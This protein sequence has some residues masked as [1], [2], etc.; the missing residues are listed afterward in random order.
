LT[1]RV[2]CSTDTSSGGNFASVVTDEDTVDGEPYT[3]DRYSLVS[4]GLPTGVARAE[5]GEYLAPYSAGEPIQVSV[6]PENPTVSI[7]ERGSTG[8]WICAVVG[9]FGL[10]GVLGVFAIVDDLLGWGYATVK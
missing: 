8:D 4:G 10:V 6:V 1:D 7:V 2:Q 5:A 9:F 3:S